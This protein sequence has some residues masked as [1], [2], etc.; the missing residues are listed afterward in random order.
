M[1]LSTVSLQIDAMFV[2]NLPQEFLSR[3]TSFCRTS[4]DFGRRTLL[5][6][7]CAQER[8]GYEKRD[9]VTH[10]SKEKEWFLNCAFHQ[11]RL[12]LQISLQ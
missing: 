9:L 8:A 2:W 7:D 10:L 12:E 11:M 3:N 4:G 5:L 1:F 6:F